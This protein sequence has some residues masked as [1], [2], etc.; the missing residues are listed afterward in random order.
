M[1]QAPKT[2]MKRSEERYIAYNKASRAGFHSLLWS[3]PWH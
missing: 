3:L 2:D 1:H